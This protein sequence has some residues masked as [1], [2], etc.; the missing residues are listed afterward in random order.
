MPPFSLDPYSNRWTLLRPVCQPVFM[1]GAGGLDDPVI[2]LSQ[3]AT[4]VG[5]TVRSFD[6]SININ[7][8]THGR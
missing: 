6:F 2:K 5:N 8:I 7:T 1:V 3:T 4:V